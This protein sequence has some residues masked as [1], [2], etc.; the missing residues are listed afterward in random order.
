MATPQTIINRALAPLLESGES[1]TA[2]E[3]SDALTALNQLLDSW[4]NE[5]LMIYSY[6]T[7]QITMDGSSSSYTIGPSGDLVTTRPVEIMSAYMIT[8]TTSLPVGILNKEEYDSITDKT[9]TSDMA[10]YLYYEPVM[11]DGI[12]Y[13]WPVVSSTNVL[14]L[15]TRVPLTQFSSLSETVSLPPGYLRALSLNLRVEVS[16]DYNR[17]ISASLARQAMLSKRSLT[18]ANGRPIKAYTEL[19]GLFGL[20][21]PNIKTDS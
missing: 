12:I 11:P 8:G 6:Q 3:S 7:E 14:Y 18:L 5:R 9:S 10:E 15:N 21:R 17:P 1:P 2:T 13:L 20:Y 4:Q 16:D 19:P